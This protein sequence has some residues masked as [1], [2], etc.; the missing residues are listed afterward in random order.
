MSGDVHVRFRE[1]PRGQFPRVTRLVITGATREVLVDEVRPLVEQFLAARGLV[2]SSE[3]TRVTHIDDGFDF[4]GMNVRKY[5]GKLLIKPARA[6]VQRF[7]RKLRV[8]VKGS[9]T[10]RHDQL[11]R[12]LN[13]FGSDSPP[14]AA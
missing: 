6:S 5:G 12:R 8:I 1:H 7:L 13:L 9:A 3:K 14:L 11:I 2:L 10:M 4:L